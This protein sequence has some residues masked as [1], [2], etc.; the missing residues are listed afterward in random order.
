[1]ENAELVGA[2]CLTISTALDCFH[3]TRSAVNV[4]GLSNG[5]LLVSLVITPVSLKEVCLPNFDASKS[6]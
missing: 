4:R 5:F 3:Y 6:R 2:K 1:M